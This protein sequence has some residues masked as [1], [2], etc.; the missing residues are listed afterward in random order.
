MKNAIKEGFKVSG[1]LLVTVYLPAGL[2]AC[3]F[4]YAA[5]LAVCR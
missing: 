4:F 2:L 5:S 3:I 1:F